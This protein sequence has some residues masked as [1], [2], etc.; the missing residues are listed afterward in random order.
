VGFEF[1]VAESCQLYRECEAYTKASA[2][3]LLEIEYTDHPRSVYVAA[4][5]ARGRAVSVILRDPDLVAKGRPGYR[6][7]SC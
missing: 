6:F 7:E 2:T 5:R 1:A 3:R 4:C